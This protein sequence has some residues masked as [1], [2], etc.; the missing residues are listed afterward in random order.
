MPPPHQ[1][2][3]IQDYAR[4]QEAPGKDG[5]KRYVDARFDFKP[6]SKLYITPV[7]VFLAGGSAEP[8]APIDPQVLARITDMFKTAFTEEAKQDYQLVNHPGPDTLQV[9]LAVTGLQPAK[10][11]IGVTDFIPIKALFNLGREAAGAGPRVAELSA[12]L[13]V[14]APDGNEVGAALAT[15]KSE[16]TLAQSSQITWQDLEPI[17]NA[18]AK[19]FHR[20]LD[21]AKAGQPQP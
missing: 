6:Y 11:P 10:P 5:I 4:L 2:G 14:L 19:L 17:V 1:P 16:K 12:E 7:K 13:S 21:N 18:W 20:G 9:R 8:P 15:R 3:L